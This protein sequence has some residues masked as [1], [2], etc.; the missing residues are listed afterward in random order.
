MGLIDYILRLHLFGFRVDHN[1]MYSRYLNQDISQ[2]IRQRFA[3]D[4]FHKIY[5][6]IC[7]TESL[8]RITIRSQPRSNKFILQNCENWLVRARRP[9]IYRR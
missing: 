8:L 3:V 4:I 7:K 6:K 9:I 2:L 1:F 5:G